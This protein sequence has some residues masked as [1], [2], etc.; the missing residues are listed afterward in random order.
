M[1]MVTA[2]GIRHHVQQ[3]AAKDT[4]LGEAPV[5]VFIHGLCIDSL[6]S[7]YF[8]LAAP[9][10]AAGFEVLAYDMRG[11]GRSEKPATGYRLSDFVEDLH[12]L[13]NEMDVHR[14]VHLVGNSFGGTVAFSYAV[15]HPERV[16]SVVMI[17]T[18]P[19]TEDW[20]TELGAVLERA[21][22]LED[23]EVIT[24]IE[25]TYDPHTL[26]RAKSLRDGL[27]NTTIAREVPSGPLLS[28]EQIESVECPVLAIYGGDSIQAALHAK[29]LQRLLPRCRA[30]IVPNA[31]HWVLVEAPQAVRDLL[32]PWVSEHEANASLLL[33]G[34]SA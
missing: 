12:E 19:A 23:P 31:S 10:S 5:V 17:E 4:V 25:D 11:H 20:S 2:N 14:P 16:A 27:R 1:A 6:A 15:A 3:M 34:A 13:L 21:K 33:E 9:T 26:R 28:A 32:L 8:T 30:E 29:P 7:F 18:G 24:A 22:Q